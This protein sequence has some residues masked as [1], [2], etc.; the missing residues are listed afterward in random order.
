M[1]Q[2]WIERGSYALFAVLI[3][4][5]VGVIDAIFGRGLLRITAFRENHF[6]YLIPFLPLAGVWIVWGYRRF[7]RESL[8]GMTLVFEAGQQKREKIPMALVPLVM[9]G[10]WIT[11]LFGGS[12]GREGVAVQIGATLAHGIGS[13]FSYLKNTKIL[14]IMGMAAGF[15]G[16]F[17]TPLAAVFFALEVMTVGVLAY[18]ALVPSLIAAYTASFVSGQCGLEKFTVSLGEKI[19]VTHPE[20]VA[21][22]LLLGIAFGLT[23]RLFS[24][25]LGKMKKIAGEKV[26]NPYVRILAGSV[27]LALIFALL[28]QGRY[29]GLGTNLITAA[30]EGGEITHYDWVLKLVLTV[31]TL[32][33]GFQG[34]EVTPL[35]AIGASLGIVLGPFLG[36]PAMA[37]GAIGYA[38]VFG[39]ATNTLLAPIFIGL[40]VFSSQNILPCILVCI[41]SYIISGDGSIYSAQEKP[42]IH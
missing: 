32:A 37:C 4:A 33:I 3:G 18:E 27:V 38:A 36:L 31:L 9:L 5:A 2:K 22:L 16:L 20:E 35:F 24:F 10:T 7:S 30:F 26:L 1:K 41:F 25:F 40:E 34:G 12:A 21:K 42:A 6:S 8:K 13:R 19:E 39:S 28:W 11:H 29:S 14:V 23:G 17:R 15:G